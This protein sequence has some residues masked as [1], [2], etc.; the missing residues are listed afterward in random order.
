MYQFLRKIHRF[1]VQV[2]SYFYAMKLKKI[3][4]KFREEPRS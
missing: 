1:S 4:K 3:S 2:Y